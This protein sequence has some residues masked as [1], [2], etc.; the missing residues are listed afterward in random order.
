MKNFNQGVNYYILHPDEVLEQVKANPNFLIEELKNMELVDYL[1]E[2]KI[3]PYGAHTLSLVDE[4]NDKWSS[5]H[6]EYEKRNH[7]ILEE[8]RTIFQKFSSTDKNIILI[9]NFGTILSSNACLGCFSSGDI[10]L[11][12]DSSD[13]HEVIKYM[14]E[15][16][17]IKESRRGV[18]NSIMTTFSKANVL[19]GKKFYV[20]F[21]WKPI[22]RRYIIGIKKLHRRLEHFRK[23]NYKTLDNGIK[24]LS[25]NALLYFNLLHVSIGHYYNT[26]PGIRL[27]ADIDRLIRHSSDINYNK[28]FLWAK[29]DDQTIRVYTALSLTRDVLNTP[30]PDCNHLINNNIFKFSSKIKKYLWSVKKSSY[31]NRTNIFD[32]WMIDAMS[33]GMNIFTYC[34]LRIVRL[35]RT[36]S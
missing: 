24:V 10:D 16:G 36:K 35:N 27:Y 14:S 32:Q 8:T 5:I 33:E 34:L 18:P 3:L 7:N 29:E 28:I 6:R 4:N 22:A 30:I 11:S 12:A 2:N 31:I 25:D 9:E 17:Y 19:E 13:Y 20:N 1:L 21:E 15:L 26:S 23:N